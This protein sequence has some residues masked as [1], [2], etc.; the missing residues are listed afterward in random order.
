MS[1]AVRSCQECGEPSGNYN[2]CVGC[3]KARSKAYRDR[4]RKHPEMKRKRRAEKMARAM[5]RKQA[6]SEEQIRMKAMKTGIP[7]EVF[8]PYLEWVLQYCVQYGRCETGVSV[9]AEWT[10]TDERVFSRVIQG[11]DGVYTV[12]V[13]VADRVC[14]HADF[15]LEELT[16]RALEWAEVTGDPWPFGYR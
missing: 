13:D 12:T 11:A 15:T 9:L 7:V 14:Q 8:K 4:D 2:L 6:A 3:K 1:V 5:E 10:D 16:E